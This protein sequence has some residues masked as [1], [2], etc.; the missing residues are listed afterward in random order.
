MDVA[1][2]VDLAR[3]ALWISFLVAAPILGTGILVG[4]V[5]SFLQALTQI[6]DQAIA[7]VPKL[8]AVG[9]SFAVTLP[10]VLSVLL[11][12]SERLLGHFPGAH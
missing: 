11:E 4:L 8:L 7:F 3:E 2:A 9:L 1:Q 10:W 12:Y 5:I 6:Q